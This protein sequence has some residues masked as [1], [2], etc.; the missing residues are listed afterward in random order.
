MRRCILVQFAE[1]YRFPGC[2]TTSSN[3]Y[4]TRTFAF[5]IPGFLGRVPRSRTHANAAEHG[6]TTSEAGRHDQDTPRSAVKC[7]TLPHREA[8]EDYSFFPGLMGTIHVH[9]TMIFSCTEN[10]NTTN[11]AGHADDGRPDLHPPSRR[12]VEPIGTARTVVRP[13]ST[14]QPPDRTLGEKVPPRG[15]APP[16]ID[17]PQRNG[18]EKFPRRDIPRRSV[19]ENAH[20]RSFEDDRIASPERTSHPRGPPT[21]GNHLRECPTPSDQYGR[22][23]NAVPSIPHDRRNRRHVSPPGTRLGEAD[24]EAVTSCSRPARGHG[25]HGE[26]SS[27]AGVTASGLARRTGS[28]CGRTVQPSR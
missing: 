7:A 13:R 12:R 9:M 1:L 4:Y 17:S 8:R 21:S 5:H 10:T 20:G 2:T 3:A 15:K 28:P 24:N 14:F 16:K 23:H 6:A 18:R 11:T 19:G 27:R 25:T 26:P 22:S